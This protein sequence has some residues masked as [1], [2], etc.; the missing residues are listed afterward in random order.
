MNE[1]EIANG[2]IAGRPEAFDQF[3]ELYRSKIFQY[4][5]SMCGQREDAEEVA[6]ETL[7]SVFEHLGQIRGPEHL[8]AWVF[9][10]AKNACLMKRRK[11]VFAPET[12]QPLDDA[13]PSD[14]NAPLPDRVVLAEEQKHL[15][16]G[17]I[18]QLPEIYRSVVL[19]RDVEELSTEETSEVLGVSADVVKT[20]LK[21]AR[22]MLREGLER[23]TAGEWHLEGPT[24]LD[25]TC[26]RRLMDAWQSQRQT[27]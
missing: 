9:R 18:I 17:A 8:K 24:P 14:E 22:R 25:V 19:L 26:K 23:A 12:E 2:L 6:Q 1:T 10:I 21:R 13:D 27:D 16:C 20:R 5:Y 3:V 7:L 15:L 4:S 11:S